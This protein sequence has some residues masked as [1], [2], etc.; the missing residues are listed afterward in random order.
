MSTPL[1]GAE[2]TGP[3]FPFAIFLEARD[4]HIL[5]IWCPHAQIIDLAFGT[6]LD[7][8]LVAINTQS[9]I[10]L[11]LEDREDRMAAF[12]FALHNRRLGRSK[13]HEPQRSI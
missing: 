2:R 1:R 4:T 7:F 6:F 8:N 9:F 12:T 11:P 10:L 13:T 3:I 5:P